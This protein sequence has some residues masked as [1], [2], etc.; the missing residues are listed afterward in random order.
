M[1]RE[2]FEQWY[3]KHPLFTS[4]ERDG[5]GYH[6]IGADVAWQAYQAGHAASGRDE[7]LEALE[8]LL[9]LIETNEDRQGFVSHQGNI[10]REAIK[11]AK[12]ES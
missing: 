5:E 11:K 8:M 3:A 4:F 12:G 6:A 2:Q 10:A 1:L 9:S 7:L